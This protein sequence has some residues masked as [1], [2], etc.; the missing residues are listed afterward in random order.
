MQSRDRDGQIRIADRPLNGFRDPGF[1]GLRLQQAKTPEE[2]SN[3]KT[4]RDAE[5][6]KYSRRYLRQKAC[7]R[8]I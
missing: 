8:L 5:P 1:A 3:Y 7:P 2:D 4:Q 6:A